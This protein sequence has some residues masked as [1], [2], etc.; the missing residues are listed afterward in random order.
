MATAPKAKRTARQDLALNALDRA[1]REHG[2]EPPA[3]T[4]IPEW[5]KVVSVEQWRQELF[6]SGVLDRDAGNP[7]SAFKKLKDGLVAAEQVVERDGFIWPMQPG[8]T[9]LPPCPSPRM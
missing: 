1:I 9:L 2:Q 6:R 3:G 8:G 4:D 5:I 7:R